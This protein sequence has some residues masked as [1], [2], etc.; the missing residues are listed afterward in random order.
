MAR[1]RRLYRPTA[2]G[3]YC[4]D[5]RRPLLHQDGPDVFRG[6][7]FACNRLRASQHRGC[8]QK[9]RANGLSV[10][11][12]R[13]VKSQCFRSLWPRRPGYECWLDQSLRYECRYIDFSRHQFNRNICFIPTEDRGWN[14]V[15]DQDA[16]E[17]APAVLQDA[18][19]RDDSSDHELQPIFPV[20]R[21]GDFADGTVQLRAF[22]GQE[23]NYLQQFRPGLSGNS[24]ADGGTAVQGLGN[25]VDR[26]LRS[27][28]NKH[29]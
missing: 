4:P 3:E 11:Y 23:R 29:V 19:A 20:A 1:R 2:S 5:G 9:L 7:R 22:S 24:A 15:L 6:A 27:E 28:L 13:L 25:D 17:Y 26:Q 10:E 12:T 14:R 8:R 18:G 16:V 21:W